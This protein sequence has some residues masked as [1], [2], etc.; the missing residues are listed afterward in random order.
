M[1]F[2]LIRWNAAQCA[3]RKK[4]LLSVYLE[5]ESGKGSIM[6]LETICTVLRDVEQMYTVV[7]GF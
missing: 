6:H 7:T 4:A 3:A 5:T 1:S 2:Q